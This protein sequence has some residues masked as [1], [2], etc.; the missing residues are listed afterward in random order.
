MFFL[1]A[2]REK[3]APAWQGFS[4]TAQIGRQALRIGENP[5][6]SR[7]G[8]L[9]PKLFQPRMNTDEHG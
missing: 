8:S 9:K 2:H 7:G 5:G 4:A 1:P 3:F 6:G